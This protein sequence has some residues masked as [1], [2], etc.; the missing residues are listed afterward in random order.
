PINDNSENPLT[1]L[2]ILSDTGFD[3][4]TLS[5]FDIYIEKCRN[6][7][8]QIALD[9]LERY[10]EEDPE[11]IFQNCHPRQHSNCNCQFLCQKL[12]FQYPPETFANISRIIEINYDTLRSFWK[13]KCLPLLQKKLEELGYSKEEES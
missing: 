3:V 5:G 6:M 11:Q 13:R 8:I 4:P 1:L 2:D 9:N 10:V 12:V 7:D